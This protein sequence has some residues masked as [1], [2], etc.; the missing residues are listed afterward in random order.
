MKKMILIMVLM[1]GLVILTGE[2]QA[3]MQ[4]YTTTINYTGVNTAPPDVVY[5][6]ATSS[7]GSWV[8][9]RWF[10]ATGSEAKAVL[11]TALT[12][13]SMGAPVILV[14]ENTDIDEWSPCYGIFAAPIQ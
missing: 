7:D 1:C 3:A 11:A 13:W 8:G 9:P 5:I 4:W 14:L 6:N 10:V 12:A 2:A